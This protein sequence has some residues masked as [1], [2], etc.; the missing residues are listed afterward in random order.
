MSLK[1][2]FPET[3]CASLNLYITHINKLAHK[4]T[5]NQT[6]TNIHTHLH[7]NYAFTNKHTRTHKHT[8]TKYPHTNIPTPSYT[9][10]NK[11]FGYE[12]KIFKKSGSFYFIMLLPKCVGG[13]NKC[14]KKA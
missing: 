14:S 10:T 5:L 8:H 11:I 1:D 7:K 12:K 3:C 6:H 2:T 9:H 4:H 13:V